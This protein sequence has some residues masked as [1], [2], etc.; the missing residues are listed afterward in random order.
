MA[1]RIRALLAEGKLE[2]AL[3]SLIDA[4]STRGDRLADDATLL[5]SRWRSAQR[6]ADLGTIT[7]DKLAEQRAQITQGALRLLRD[8]GPSTSRGA[9]AAVGKL[10]LFLA[11]SAELRQD[12]D[13]FD[14]YV[15]Q[16]NDLLGKQGIYIE[17]VRWET[18]LDAMSETRL[19]DEYNEAVAAADIFVGLFFT[20]MGKFTEEEF[21]V[22][23]R[24]FEETGR[25]RIYTYFKNS[26]VEM[27]GVTRED[28]ES[29]RAFQDRLAKLGHYVTT[30]DSVED[31][32]LKFRRQLD[33]LDQLFAGVPRPIC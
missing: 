18:F 10:K 28:L 20:K 5:I 3:Q 8:L 16:Q 12:R 30:Y 21:D 7:S 32:Q 31:L 22:A 26:R 15:R 27:T 1:D 4:A 11:S 6:A 29:L 33:R 19:Q 24:R 13:A 9:R 25:P 23:R 2:D 14:L 17:V